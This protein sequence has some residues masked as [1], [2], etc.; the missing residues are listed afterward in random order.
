MKLLSNH[1]IPPFPSVT[2]TLPHTSKLKTEDENKKEN[3]SGTPW[4]VT[5]RG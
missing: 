2:K 1:R 3:N 5:C 4:E